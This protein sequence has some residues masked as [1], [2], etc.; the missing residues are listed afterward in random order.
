MEWIVLPRRSTSLVKNDFPSPRRVLTRFFLPFFFIAG[1]SLACSLSLDGPTP[2]GPILTP[3]A[4]Q[5][6]IDTVWSQAYSARQNGQWI[7]IFNENQLTTYFESQLAKRPD[8]PLQEPQISLR[9][10]AIGVYG[11]YQTE[12]L[13]ALVRIM[14][15]PNVREDGTVEW[16]VTNAQFGSAQVPAGVLSALTD[17]LN[18]ALT[19]KVGSIATGFKIKEVLIG[20][21]QIA[22]RCHAGA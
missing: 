12:Y 20:D 10:G 13:T 6:D 3:D 17:T 19:G 2:P 1:A 21:G 18:G 5:P 9:D 16:S 7:V 22:I 15:Q 11:R 14:L 4:T 8:I